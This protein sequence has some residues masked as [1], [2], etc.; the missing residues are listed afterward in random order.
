MSENPWSMAFLWAHFLPYILLAGGVVLIRGVRLRL[1]RKE[2]GL[3]GIFLSCIFAEIIMLCYGNKM[4]IGSFSRIDKY[5]LDRYF[6]TFSPF[7]WIFTAYLLARAWFVKTQRVILRGLARGI[8]ILFLGFILFEVSIHNFMK[9]YRVSGGR[10]AMEAARRIAPVIRKDYSGPDRYPNFQ[11]QR[12]EYFTSRRP[13][14][15]SYF[16]AAA[17]LTGGQSE[18]ANLDNYPYPEDY[19]FIRVG[20]GYKQMTE[21]IDP[22]KYEYMASVRGTY[23]LWRLFRRKGTPHN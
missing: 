1:S 22:T 9:H 2:L 20:Q 4:F 5:G 13:V 11:Y 12:N 14:V 19:L 18:G 3:V 10:D 16:G 15:F 6:G 23:C 21:R 7:A 8:I 17:W